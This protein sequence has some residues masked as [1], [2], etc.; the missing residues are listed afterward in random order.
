MK[1]ALVLLV[2]TV[3]LAFG[4]HAALAHPSSADVQT[5]VVVVET[6]LA[7][8]NGSAEGTG[9]VITSSGE[10]LT[11][12]HVIRGSTTVKVVVPQTQKAYTA[13]VVGYTVSGDLAVNVE[14]RPSVATSVS[15]L[16]LKLKRTPLRT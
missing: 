8:E 3:A 13:R 5:G 1:R 9:I 16:S 11:N 10:V 12:N 4:V 7:Y 2:A 14:V 6:K 15:L